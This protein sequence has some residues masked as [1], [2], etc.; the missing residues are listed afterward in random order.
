MEFLDKSNCLISIHFL[1]EDTKIE[2]LYHNCVHDF[3]PI[4]QNFPRFST[5]VGE[6]LG[7]PFVST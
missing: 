4:F 3:F 5:F 2:N 6:K 1:G 7:F